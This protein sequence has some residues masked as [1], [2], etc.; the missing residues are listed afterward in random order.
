MELTQVSWAPSQANKKKK[1]KLGFHREQTIIWLQV[2]FYS[3]SRWAASIP[4]EST[5][6]YPVEV[7]LNQYL[8]KKC[9]STR[10]AEWLMCARL[11]H[12]ST[13]LLLQCGQIQHKSW[14][15]KEKVSLDNVAYG[16]CWTLWV[17][18]LQLLGENKTKWSCH[19]GL[20]WIKK[21]WRGLSLKQ[22]QTWSVLMKCCQAG[23][24]PNY[25]CS[26]MLYIAEGA[27]VWTLCLQVKLNG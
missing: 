24:I 19:G 5:L 21:V 23:E 3:I 7:W 26:K 4:T 1:K 25:A 15:R 27:W 10:T 20:K 8:S 9:F 6:M 14:W 12:Q 18:V 13:F 11:W 17:G 2:Y 22:T 16:K